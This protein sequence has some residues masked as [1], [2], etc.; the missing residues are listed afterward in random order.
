MQDLDYLTLRPQF[1]KLPIVGLSLKQSYVSSNVMFTNTGAPQGTV[2]CPF[3]F[4]L[5]TADC[6]HKDA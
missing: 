2:L 1:V 6:R 3:L 4:I 5:Y